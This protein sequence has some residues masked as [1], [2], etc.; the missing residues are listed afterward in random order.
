MSE[1]FDHTLKTANTLRE[2]L[3]AIENRAGAL[4]II[5]N[6][7][8]NEQIDDGRLRG[9]VAQLIFDILSGVERA[10]LLE[11]ELHAAPAKATPPDERL[12][13]LLA[14]M[15]PNQRAHFRVQLYE[16]MHEIDMERE[17]AAGANGEA[18]P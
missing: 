14:E 17:H 6:E 10:A 18:Q 11:E 12:H 9:S 1:T 4:Q 8:L 3:Y 16:A 5:F 13:A 15:S 7:A 2:E